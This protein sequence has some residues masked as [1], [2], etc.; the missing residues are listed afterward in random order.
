[1]GELGWVEGRNILVEFRWNIDAARKSPHI[2]TWR[3]GFGQYRLV[4]FWHRLRRVDRAKSC[5]EHQAILESLAA[6]QCDLGQMT[7]LIAAELISEDREGERE[8]IRISNA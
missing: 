2:D 8:R 7:S 4:L 5:R 1:L 6:D 3:E